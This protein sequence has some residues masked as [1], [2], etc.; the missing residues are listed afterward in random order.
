MRSIKGSAK[1]GAN[2][3]KGLWGYFSILFGTDR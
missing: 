3:K 1:V 2:D